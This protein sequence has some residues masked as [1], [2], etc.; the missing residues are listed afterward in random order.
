VQIA[1]FG[2][3][4]DAPAEGV[5]VDPAEGDAAGTEDGE[6]D[7]DTDGAALADGCEVSIP[8]PLGPLDGLGPATNV[9]APAT[10]VPQPVAAAVTSAA[11]ARSFHRCVTAGPFRSR[12]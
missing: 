5:G 10:A 3:S 2:R 12:P 7:G 1:P 6:A 9:P 4:P 8:P 11:A